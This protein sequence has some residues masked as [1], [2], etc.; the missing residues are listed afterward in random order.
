MNYVKSDKQTDKE[1]AMVLWLTLLEINTV[2]RFQN[3]NEAVCILRSPNTR[4]IGRHP[5]IF[6]PVIG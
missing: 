6:P 5:I 4:W 1:A 2:T 3:L